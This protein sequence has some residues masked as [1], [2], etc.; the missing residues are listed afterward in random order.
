M[1]LITILIYAGV[2]AFQ[3]YKISLS[4]AYLKSSTDVA[5]LGQSSKGG[6]ILIP[7]LNEQKII[8]DSYSRFKKAVKGTNFHV[9]FITTDKEEKI[10]ADLTTREMLNL[11]IAEDNNITLINSP[12][13]QGVMAHQLNYAIEEITKQA[14]ENNPYFMIYNADSEIHK[15]TITYISGLLNRDP[16]ML[17]QQ[18]S[19][20]DH[21][22]PT[23]FSKK[24]LS[25]ISLWQSRWSLQFEL[26]RLLFDQ[27]F[28]SK[29]NKWKCFYPFKPFHYVIGHGLG[30][31]YNSWLL[32]TGFPEDELNEDA[33]LGYILHLHKFNMVSV[34]VLEKADSPRALNIYLKQQAVW[35]NGPLY[36]YSY[37]KKRLRGRCGR[38][39]NSSIAVNFKDRLFAFATASKLFLHAV[40]WILGPLIIFFIYPLVSL[41]SEEYLY[42]FLWLGLTVFFCYYINYFTR[43]TLLELGYTQKE[44]GGVIS[45]LV[46]YFMHCLGPIMT[47]KKIL[48]RKNTMDN[49]YKTQ[50]D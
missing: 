23:N 33:F 41:L 6:Y 14:D 46:A 35:F 30:I 21:E 48:A 9:V 36:A 50:K 18:Y 44:C 12:N 32:C 4:K 10:G 22:E 27:K 5:A 26:G 7:V 31:S 40:Y 34:P 16:D 24:I 37:F 39:K 1:L 29:I 25:H 11:L 8:K 3:I 43:K 15:N 49:K 47:I 2:C 28:F 17:V 38:H 42:A 45:A 19:Y 13:K 20:Y